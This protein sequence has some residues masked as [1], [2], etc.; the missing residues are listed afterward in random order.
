[1]R[2]KRGKKR[3]IMRKKREIMRKKKRNECVQ[4]ICE[5]RIRPH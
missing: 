5:S 3:E 4:D 1:V 2:K